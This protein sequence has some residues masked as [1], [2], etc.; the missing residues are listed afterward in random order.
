MIKI[1]TVNGCYVPRICCD[2][3]TLPIDDAKGALALW[4]KGLEPGQP[5]TVYYVHKGDCDRKLSTQLRQQ[6][7][8][9]VNEYSD[10]FSQHIVKLLL[11]TNMILLQQKSNGECTYD[12]SLLNEAIGRNEV[13]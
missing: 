7:G 11:N 9:I 2:Q 4:I 1:F 13:V 10:E 12:L 6:A 5:E 8:Y 3:C